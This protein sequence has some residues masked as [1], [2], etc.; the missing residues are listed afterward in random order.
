MRPAA[1]GLCVCSR[2]ELRRKSVVKQQ[3]G[4]FSCS[5]F[6]I[7][8]GERWE[9]IKLNSLRGSAEQILVSI[10]PHLC[11][12]AGSSSCKLISGASVNLYTDTNKDFH[13][14]KTLKYSRILGT[15]TQCLRA[16]L[17]WCLGQLKHMTMS[18]E[19]SW[20][21]LA[22]LDKLLRTISQRRERNV[23]LW[24]GT[25]GEKPLHFVC[26][27]TTDHLNHDVIM[28]THPSPLLLSENV[29]E[30]TQGSKWKCFTVTISNWAPIISYLFCHLWAQ[31]LNGCGFVQSSTT[32]KPPDWPTFFHSLIFSPPL[33]ECQ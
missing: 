6:G 14:S 22:L 10:A 9:E 25:T 21:L 20:L 32:T 26:C 29:Q 31:S 28:V 3:R 17:S 2:P 13:F 24:K 5:A 4:C 11:V 1:H 18:A 16:P 23:S 30:W 15:Y 27:S 33:P 12:W 7:T 8:S 19:I